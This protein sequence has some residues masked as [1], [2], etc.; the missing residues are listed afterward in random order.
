MAE[1]EALG[2]AARRADGLLEAVLRRW[3]KV[4]VD[5]VWQ[6][7]DG[8]TFQT[9]GAAL[10]NPWETKVVRTRGI[11]NRLVLADHGDMQQRTSK[12]IMSRNSSEEWTLTRNLKNNKISPA[13]EHRQ[14]FPWLY[15]T[16]GRSLK[17]IGENF[18]KLKPACVRVSL[19]LW[20]PLL[21]YGYQIKHPV[22]DWVEQLFVFFDIRALWR[23]AVS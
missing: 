13:K 19:T 17:L 11:G 5:K 1:S 18:A 6:M 23:S 9:V 12:F 14:M 10:L 22:P 8:S 16:S 3:Q 21:L 2:W 15:E 7:S 4:W 20:C